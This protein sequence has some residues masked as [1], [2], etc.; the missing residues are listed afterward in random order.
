MAQDVVA[1]PPPPPAA[2]KPPVPPASPHPG[3]RDAGNAAA[4]V[5]QLLESFER[6]LAAVVDGRLPGFGFEN[7]AASTSLKALVKRLDEA[8]DASTALEDLIK[9]LD[10]ADIS[11]DEE[12]G[13]LFLR[14]GKPSDDEAAAALDRVELRRD[15][16][17]AVVDAIKDHVEEKYGSIGSHGVST[18]EETHWVIRLQRVAE[19]KVLEKYWICGESTTLASVSALLALVRECGGAARAAGERLQARLAVPRLSLNSTMA[20]CGTCKLATDVAAIS[21]SATKP[22]DLDEALGPITF[23]TR[24]ATPLTKQG[25]REAPVLKFAAPEAPAGGGADARA[26][27]RGTGFTLKFRSRAAGL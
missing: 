23:K 11:A 22:R 15:V 4:A 1:A 8:D 17:V 24:G 20:R 7:D 13:K 10:T 3:D 5:E 19:G 27:R 12:G 2:A 9:T 18:R 21:A 14:A 26:V 6:V 25:D 16:F